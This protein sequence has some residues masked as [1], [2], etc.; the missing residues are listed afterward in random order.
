M[1]ISALADAINEAKGKTEQKENEVI[2]DDFLNSTES[3][4]KQDSG[5]YDHKDRNTKQLDKVNSDSK[6]VT[7]DIIDVEAKEE[8]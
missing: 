8:E 6:I 5:K 1:I 2:K 4:T 3:L 7:E